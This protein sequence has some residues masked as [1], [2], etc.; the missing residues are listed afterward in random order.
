MATA[1]GLAKVLPPPKYSA[2]A[3]KAS[4][5]Q[6]SVENKGDDDSKVASLRIPA[7]PPY[8]MRGKGN[9]V[10]KKIEDFGDGGAYPE[11]QHVQYPLGMG[12]PQGNKSGSKSNALALQVDQQG[13]VDYAAIARQ[14]HSSERIIQSSLKD[15][16]PLRQRA[17]VGE[18]SLDRP[19][20]EEVE[21]TAERTK[22]ALEKLANGQVASMKPKN[23][24]VQKRAD[25]TYV[26]Y[27]PASQMGEEKAQNTRIIKLVEKMQDPMEPPKFKQKKLPRGPP[28]PPPPVM[29]SPPRKLSAKEKADWKIP[30]AV[31]NWKN[32]KGYTIPLDKR[33][34]ADGRGLIDVQIND[35]F[36]KLSEA[37]GTA[38]RHARDEI[39][40]RASLQQ[41]LAAKQRQE[42]EEYL[43]MLAQRARDER[44]GY[45]DS[46]SRGSYYSDE[47]ER[48]SDDE[49]AAR[50]REEIRRERRRDAERNMRMSNMGQEQRMRV[51][52]REQNRDISEKVA[53]GLAKPT[54]SKDSMFDARL[55]NQS[56]GASAGIG[57]DDS[58]NVY[59][60]PL[61][62][63]QEAAQSIYRPRPSGEEDETEEDVLQRATKGGRFEVLGKAAHGFKGADVA[64]PR[65][66]P[67]VFKKAEN[68]SADFGIDA[69]LGE[70]A[71]SVE[72]KRKIGLNTQ[73]EKE[74][75]S[76]PKRKRLEE[77]DE[78]QGS[79]E[80]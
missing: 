55:Y 30:P 15:L 8:G 45:E 68:D 41:K 72:Q 38:E 46:D 31:S 64:E 13:Q 7:P 4:S 26:R 6:F 22:A 62:A 57:A 23:V 25:P 21:E 44:A 33:M 36:A 50:E 16:V 70:V 77:D 73:E 75:D 52:A 76:G 53:L 79:D 80:E 29:H 1:A 78:L 60:K 40:Q 27:T 34:A 17:D 43:R 59:D 14:G 3:S 19:S 65:R 37:L 48:R 28:S 2:S 12:L 20:T 10:P 49:E 9:W 32:P 39:R 54:A 47:E 24:N 58:Y 35:N 63:A 66:G 56:T 51:L 42:K 74:G 5:E 71:N 67:V 18:I 11:I 69:F 61:F